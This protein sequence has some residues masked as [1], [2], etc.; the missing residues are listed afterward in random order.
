MFLIAFPYAISLEQAGLDLSHPLST[1][2]SHPLATLFMPFSL[3][4]LLLP[5]KLISHVLT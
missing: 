3:L 2:A 5:H 1:L 4:I